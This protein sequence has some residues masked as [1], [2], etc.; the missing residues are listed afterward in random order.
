[1]KFF[2]VLFFLF[3]SLNMGRV[4]S[5]TIS[6]VRYVNIVEL[7]KDS[8][9]ALNLAMNE[10]KKRGYSLKDYNLSLK[11]A[12]T[13]NGKKYY[14]VN[15]SQVKINP[16]V[17]GGGKKAFSVYVDTSTEEIAGFYLSR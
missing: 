10:A 11:N 9:Y 13:E 12:W 2:S 1:M 16:M 17:K 15:F 7:D 3:L 14:T 6:F 8:V 5:D 4:M